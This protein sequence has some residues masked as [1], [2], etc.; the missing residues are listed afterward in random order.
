MTVAG[1]GNTD[2]T[3]VVSG[4]GGLT[5]S[6]AGTLNLTAANTYTGTTTVAA[7]T[8]KAN[9]AASAVLLTGAGGVDVQGGKLVLDYTGGTS[10]VVSVKTILDAGYAGG[11]TAGQ[12]KSTTLP[13]GRTLGYGD[14]GSAVTIRVTLAG[15]ADLD[16]DVDFNDFLVLQANFG[17]AN[18]RF[19]QGNFNY[20]GFTD[21]NDFLQL[22]ASFGQSVTG[23][24]V[25]FTS[26][27]VAAMTAF[28][29]VV[30]EPG[31]LALIGL[32]AGLVGRRRRSR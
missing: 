26:A 6:G 31:S 28:A 2:L 29:S 32:G 9:E 3:G 13:G 22:Q 4:T 11:F 21:F 23:D 12:I 7:G 30:P 10:P 19:D 16:G 24:E 5:K 25:A 27:Q 1:S 14:N 8:L 20:D 17:T 15:D 18:T